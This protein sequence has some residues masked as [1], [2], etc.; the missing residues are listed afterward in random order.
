MTER[1]RHEYRRPR[2]V[3]LSVDDPEEVSGAFA[4]LG[5]GCDDVDLRAVSATVAVAVMRRAL[6]EGVARAAVE[7]AVQAVQDLRWQLEY[8]AVVS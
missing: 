8:P 1:Y 3:H 6:Q 7:D 4:N 2:G 5:L